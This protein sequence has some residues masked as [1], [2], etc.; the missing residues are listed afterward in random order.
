VDIDA[1]LSQFAYQVTRLPTDERG[2]YTAKGVE[3]T[4]L[5]ED[6]CALTREPRPRIR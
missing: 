2:F 3:L 5:L 6:A 4:V 1:K